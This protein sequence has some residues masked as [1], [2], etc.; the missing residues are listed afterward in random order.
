MYRTT[1]D[2]ILLK[3]DACAIVENMMKNKNGWNAT[4]FGNIFV[5]C[6]NQEPPHL[7][8]HSVDSIGAWYV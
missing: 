2:D 4:V 3:H 1:T 7:A 6:E 5:H 8:V